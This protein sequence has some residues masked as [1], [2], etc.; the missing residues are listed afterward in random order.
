MSEEEK[1][2]STLE[3]YQI[4][5]DRTWSKIRAKLYRPLR[6]LQTLPGIEENKKLQEIIE[7]TALDL[8]V[9]YH[10]QVVAKKLTNGDINSQSVRLSETF[11]LSETGKGVR[12]LWRALCEMQKNMP[13]EFNQ[14]KAASLGHLKTSE[15]LLRRLR[16]DFQELQDVDVEDINLDY[17][18]ISYMLIGS[19]IGATKRAVAG[20]SEVFEGV[21]ESIAYIGYKHLQGDNIRRR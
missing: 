21:P 8:I 3:A 5:D 1:P 18:H 2:T 19:I 13:S 16:S 7:E 11:S 14:L 4:L 10:Q 15:P 17:R 12:R 6:A 9:T 20:D